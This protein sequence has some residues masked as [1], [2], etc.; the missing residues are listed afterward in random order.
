MASGTP[1]FFEA[2]LEAL[3][4]RDR[5]LLTSL[6]IIVCVVGV[7]LLW[8]TLYGML[9]DR[10]SRVMEMKGQLTQTLE[11]QQDYLDAA[12]MIRSNED[13]LKQFESQPLSA[14]LEQV[15]EKHGIQDELDDVE[16]GSTTQ[17]GSIKQTNFHVKWK[18]VPFAE[19]MDLLYE[20]ETS[21]YPLKI[22]DATLKV[23]Y[24]KREKM[25]DLIL[26]MT[27]FKLTA[28]E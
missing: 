8:W 6:V 14:Y 7:A 15:A 27:V 24:I 11:L 19:A 25:L 5:M 22:T 12:E 4:P 2:Q 9:Q 28:E 17:V 1:G 26:E 10:A 18:R 3:S 16:A 23:S 20:I 21:G 13:R